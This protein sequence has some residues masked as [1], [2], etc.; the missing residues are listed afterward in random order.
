MIEFA[1]TCDAVAATSA[2]LGKIERLASYFRTLA[3]ADLVAAARFFAGTPLGASD[4]RKLALGG[5]TIAAVA[6]RLWATGDAALSHAYRATG[7]LGEAL[8]ALWREPA[9]PGLFSETL[10]P[11]GFAQILDE[12]ADAAGPGAGKRREAACERILRACHDPRE[13]VYTI[14]ILTGDLRIGLRAG[15]V[16]DAIAAA[17]ERAPDLV[18]RAAMAAGDTG[19]VALAARDDRLE[20]IGI[21]YGAPIGFMLASPLAFGSSYRELCDGTWLVED[22]FDGIRAQAH[23]SDGTVR[24]FSRTFSP[25]ERAFPEIVAAL[26][27]QRGDFILDGEIVARRDGRTLPF[28]YLQPRLQRVAPSVELQ[29]D[30]PAVFVAFDILASDASFLIDRPLLERRAALT[31]ALA[32]DER[33]EIASCERLETA[34]PADPVA[35]AFDDARG[36]GHEGLVFKR[37][38][39]VYTPG[40]RGKAWLKLKR[41]LS[42]LDCVVVGVEWGNGKRAKV[43]SD[44][45]FAVRR[46]AEDPELLT[47]GKAYTGLTDVEIAQMTE[48]FL[49]HARGPAER[50]HIPVDPEIVVEIAFDIIQRSELHAGGFALRFPR[51]VRL[52]PDKPAAECD[53]LGDVERIYREMLEREGV[54]R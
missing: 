46:S 23:R 45:T 51:I 1:R 28:R 49:T 24:L 19:A 22:K 10:T 4:P 44:Y 37:A 54:E 16:L 33:L 41:E 34:Q 47:L 26:A 20:Q 3:P 21:A 36:R 30:I 39:S 31:A 7:D 42:T 40:R 15:L 11:A 35:A 50:H 25:L 13:A 8:G 43:L 48:W 18:R 27:A 12:L 2:K 5:R 17:F 52:R 32:P 6:E 14:K 53:T 9:V 29:A 38:D